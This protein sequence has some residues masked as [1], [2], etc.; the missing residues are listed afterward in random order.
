MHLL[1]RLYSWNLDSVYYDSPSI[2][3]FFEAILILYNQ[4]SSSS[5]P[6]PVATFRDI[7]H[8][9]YYTI[10][11]MLGLYALQY[12]LLTVLLGS[13]HLASWGCWHWLESIAMIRLFVRYVSVKL[14]VPSQYEQLANHP[15]QHHKGTEQILCICF[16][17]CQSMVFSCQRT[18]HNPSWL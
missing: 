10:T 17:S 15:D 13:L 6:V 14:G 7:H 2:K 8:Y 1:P 11:T 18:Q 3:S 5:P 4:Y 12:L 16:K 9:I